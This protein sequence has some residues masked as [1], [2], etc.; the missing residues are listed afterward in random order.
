MR[1]FDNFVAIDW[2]G[3]KGERQ[4]GIALAH[5]AQGNRAPTLLTP[6]GGWSREKILHWLVRHAEAGT[7]MLI[8]LDLSPAFAFA[9]RGAYFPGWSESSCDA[10]ALWSLVDRIA[11]DDPHLA[12]NAFVE[13]PEARRHFR[14]QAYCGDLFEPGAGRMRQ[15]ERNQ[16]AQGLSPYSCFNLIGA[17]QVG[18]SSLTGMRVLNRL[19]G[20]IPLWPLDDVPAEGPLLVEIYTAIPAREAGIRKRSKVRDGV[21]LDAALAAF[22]SETHQPLPRYDDHATDA[23][24]TAAWLRRAAARPELWSPHGLTPSLARTEG[25]TFGVL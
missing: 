24:L 16:R 21:T 17:A 15:A 19:A 22:D 9:D 23:I 10:K 3:A 8:G 14:H 18:K 1:R 6:T 25:W 7:D 20:R 5:V 4:Q 13:H 2:S 12:A 11:G